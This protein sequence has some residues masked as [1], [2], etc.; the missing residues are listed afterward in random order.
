M[1]LDTKTVDWEKGNG[2]VPAIV[3]DASTEQVL[4]LGYMNA[5]SLKKTPSPFIAALVKHCG[6][7]EKQ[8]EIR[9]SLSLLL[10]TAIKT[11]C[12]FALCPLDQ[13]VTKALYHV[14]EIKAHKG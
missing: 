12:S 8:A 6:P 9:L 13:P 5:E 3:Q 2:L 7:R 11:Q 10:L 14:S 4:M 1:T